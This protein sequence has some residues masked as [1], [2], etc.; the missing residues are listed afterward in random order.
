MRRIRDMTREASGL[1]SNSLLPSRSEIHDQSEP[2]SVWESPG[3]LRASLSSPE[4]RS[5]ILTSLEWSPAP[6]G[7]PRRLANS[8]SGKPSLQ[9]LNTSNPGGGRSVA[10]RRGAEGAVG[11]Q[12]IGGGFKR[13]TTPAEPLTRSYAAKI[14][15]DILD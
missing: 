2:G 13:A 5:E 7:H 10:E 3:P 8:A 12:A 11:D 4:A 6:T 1:L 9:H 15:R 14:S